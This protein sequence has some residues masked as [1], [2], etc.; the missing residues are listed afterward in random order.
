MTTPSNQSP[1]ATSEGHEQSE[2]ARSS[3]ETRDELQSLARTH[4]D[5]QTR[6]QELVAGHVLQ[7]SRNGRT[8]DERSRGLVLR[9]RQDLLAELR[10]QEQEEARRDLVTAAD[11]SEDAVAG[12]VQGVTTIVRSLVPA[13]LVRPE[14]A[15]E[16]AF[17]LADQGLRVARRL[18]LAVTGGVRSI[19]TV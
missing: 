8:D 4:A 1:S 14:E 10:A 2:T 15:I 18:G 6:A 11:R 17:A 3:D 12:V 13:V 7:E 5:T 19:V 16:T 9:A